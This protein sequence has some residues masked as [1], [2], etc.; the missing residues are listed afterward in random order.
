MLNL[1]GVIVAFVIIILLIRKKFNFGL[2]LIIGSI[3]VGLFS[4]QE[5]NLIDIPKAFSKAILYDFDSQVFDFNTV[6]LA[7]LL[8]LIYILAKCMQ[9]TGAITKLIDSLRSIFTK[10]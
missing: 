4:L 5:I 6:E 10:G 2:S 3:I 1:I 8:S 9:E 7:L